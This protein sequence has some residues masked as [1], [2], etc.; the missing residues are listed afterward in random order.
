M[1]RESIEVHSSYIT[2]ANC[3]RVRLSDSCLHEA[4]QLRIELI[5][6]LHRSDFLI[7]SHYVVDIRINLRMKDDPH[8]LPRRCSIRASN[9]SSE[10][11]VDGCALSSESRRRASAMPSSWSCST[12][13]SDPSKCAARTARWFSGKSR[14][15]FSTS[16]IVATT[17]SLIS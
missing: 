2:C 3:E 16:V 8:Q 6:E 1:I 7:I 12:D 10:I 15:S 14:A 9:S 4:P 17:G 13:G 5:R 11:P